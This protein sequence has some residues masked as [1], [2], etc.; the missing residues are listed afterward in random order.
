MEDELRPEG[1]SLRDDLVR[2][3][4]DHTTG[5]SEALQNRYARLIGLAELQMQE[6]FEMLVEKGFAEERAAQLAETDFCIAE[7]TEKD[8]FKSDNKNLRQ[9]FILTRLPIEKRLEN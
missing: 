8:H 2:T 5:I 1:D 7:E 6:D 4:W 9:Y 3:A